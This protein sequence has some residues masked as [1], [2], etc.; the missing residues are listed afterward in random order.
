ML[1]GCLLFQSGGKIL[2]IFSHNKKP[3]TKFI[4]TNNSHLCG[5]DCVDLISKMLEF[6]HSDRITASEAMEHPYF[7]PIKERFDEMNSKTDTIN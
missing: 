4:N 2:L 3:F 5:P 6:D 7:K 1:K